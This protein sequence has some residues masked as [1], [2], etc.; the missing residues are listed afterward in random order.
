MLVSIYNNNG[1]KDVLM[2]MLQNYPASKQ[3][4]ETKS[5]ITAI[6]TEDGQEVVGYNFFD[7]S[8]IL[9]EL[10]NGPVTLTEAQ[11]EVL[12]NQLSAH[13]FTQLLSADTEPKFVVGVVK[14]CGPVKDS[15]HL[16]VTTIDVEGEEPLQIVCGAANIAAD[17]HVVVARPGAVMPDGTVI[18]PGELRGVKS[19][20]M[21]CSATELGMPTDGSQKGILVLDEQTKAGERFVLPTHA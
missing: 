13:G 6:K 18:W 12:N 9:G 17:Q 11:V 14:T 10:E 8:A 21:V 20:G 16:S 1:L 5:K 19:E 7:A 4:I 3:V 2:I 15:D